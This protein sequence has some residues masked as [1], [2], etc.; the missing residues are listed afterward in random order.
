MKKTITVI[1]GTS[2]GIGEILAKHYLSLGHI[3]IGCSR[4]LPKWAEYSVDNYLHYNLD[5]AD[6][7][8]VRKMFS[9]IRQKYGYIDNLINNAGI[10][11]MNHSVL[12][13]IST[14]ENILKTNTIGT[15]LFSREAFKLM[16]TQKY[17]RIVN[18]TTVATPLKLEGEAAYAASK[19]AIISLTQIMAKEFADFGVTVNAIG[20][21]PIKTDL[22]KNV[23]ADKIE[24][25]LDRQS[26]HRFG[27]FDDVINVMDFYLKKESAFITGQ[28][29]FLGGV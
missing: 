20:P 1:T 25:L 12:T 11:A 5:V 21:T 14:V 29:L 2:R 4:D 24:T 3:V 16:K 28:V 7:S 26:I 6:E 18:F 9:E 27:T 23:P 10:A 17:G 13:P 8:K 22:I 19:A 15:F